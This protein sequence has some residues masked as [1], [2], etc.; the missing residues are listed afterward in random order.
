M[1]SSDDDDGLCSHLVSNS[2]F[3]SFLFLTGVYSSCLGDPFLEEKTGE[4]FASAGSMDAL[5]TAN[6]GAPPT[7]N[8]IK[9]LDAPYG[10]STCE[11]AAAL[12]TKPYRYNVFCNG[13]GTVEVR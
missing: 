6:E 3:F 11:D 4:I 5:K 12:G 2:F 1:T 8:E 9:L 10:N 7:G 13:D